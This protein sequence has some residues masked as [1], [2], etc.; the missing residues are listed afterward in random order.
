MFVDELFCLIYPVGFSDLQ[1][2]SE[3]PF[4]GTR[5]HGLVE[6]AQADAQVF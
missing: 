5:L 4:L 1:T 6:S 2:L 3:I